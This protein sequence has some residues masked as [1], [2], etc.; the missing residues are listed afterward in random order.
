MKTSLLLALFLLA[1]GCV[2][3]STPGNSQVNGF[4]SVEESHTETAKV[5]QLSNEE[6][7]QSVERWLWNL[8][9]NER[10]QYDTQLEAARLWLLMNEHIP[11]C[12]AP[13][14]Q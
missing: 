11:G 7:K 1:P 5:I 9:T 14:E 8:M 3:E 6:Q 2:N 13:V 4:D 12:P 10:L